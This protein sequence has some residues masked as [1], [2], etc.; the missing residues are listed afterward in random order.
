MTTLPYRHRPKCPLC[1]SRAAVQRPGTGEYCFPCR[2]CVKRHVKV[3][4]QGARIKARI[5][6]T[7]QTFDIG[8]MVA[9]KYARRLQG[10][11]L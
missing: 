6:T 9:A 1:S 7:G 10:G 4:R 11:L 3:Y 8:H 2:T 5:R